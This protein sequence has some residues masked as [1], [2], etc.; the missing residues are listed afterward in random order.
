MPALPIS[1]GGLWW[2]RWPDGQSGRWGSEEVGLCCGLSRDFLNEERQNGAGYIAAL[3]DH[4]RCHS[5]PLL[6]CIWFGI[7]PL[8]SLFWLAPTATKPAG[9]SPWKASNQ[10]IASFLSFPAAAE[11][12]RLS[13]SVE[14]NP[15]LSPSPHDLAPPEPSS[16]RR[17]TQTPQPNTRIK[18]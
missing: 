2:Q 10:A 1:A 9:Q 4:R 16:V 13:A 18:S 8:D 6:F 5:I 15:F 11:L 17:Q 12:S 3:P 14:A 7:S